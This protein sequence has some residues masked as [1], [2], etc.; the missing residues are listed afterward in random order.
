MEDEAEAVKKG[1]EGLRR[2]E[3]NAS[4]KDRWMIRSL[5]LWAVDD[6]SSLPSSP[7]LPTTPTRSISC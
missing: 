4:R 6:R 1:M 5:G 3:M 7:P 2:D